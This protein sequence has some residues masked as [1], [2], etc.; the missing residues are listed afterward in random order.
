MSSSVR[1]PDGGLTSNVGTILEGALKLLGVRFSMAIMELADA[2]NAFFQVLLFGAIAILASAF[3]LLSISG[4]IVVLAWEA[5]GWRIFLIL[6]LGYLLLTLVLLWRARGIIASGKIGLPLTL[7]E[8]K[9]DRVVFFDEQGDPD[10][11]V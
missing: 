5:L 10:C 6:F 8:L 1:P 7:A 2:R 9:K 3:A 4:M 11:R